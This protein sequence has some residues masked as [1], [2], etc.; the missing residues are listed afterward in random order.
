MERE[1]KI[2]ENVLSV[3]GVPDVVLF[4]EILKMADIFS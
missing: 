2:S 3:S 4:Q 1:R